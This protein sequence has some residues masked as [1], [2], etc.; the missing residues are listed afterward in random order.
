MTPAERSAHAARLEL[1]ELADAAMKAR[2]DGDQLTPAFRVLILQA[3][4]RV[5]IAERRLT[6]REQA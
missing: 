3:R 2:E 1:A 5:R 4:N 6:P